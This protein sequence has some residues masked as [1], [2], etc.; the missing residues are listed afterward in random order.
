MCCI[1]VKQHKPFSHITSYPPSAARGM[2]RESASVSLAKMV[3]DARTH[4]AVFR[5]CYLWYDL[6]FSCT[7]Y[8]TLD[9]RRH[10]LFGLHRC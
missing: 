5:N 10:K 1:A 7:V 9:D 4:L 6:A 3:R 2:Q 8:L